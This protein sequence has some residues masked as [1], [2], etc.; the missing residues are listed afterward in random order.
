MHYGSLRVTTNDALVVTVWN[1]I[2]GQTVTIRG[3]YITPLG[4]VVPFEQT[5]SPSADRLPNTA[6]VR[7]AEGFL[8]GVKVSASAAIQRGQTFVRIALGQGLQTPPPE[9]LV[10]AQD[11]VTQAV[12]LGWPGGRISSPTEGPG[13]IRSIVG[14]TPAPGN[15]WIETVP[16]NARWRVR[17]MSF[18]FTA[19]ATAVT[20]NIGV[21][22]DD[23]AYILRVF[24]GD[25]RGGNQAYIF[26]YDDDPTQ[27]YRTGFG[28]SPHRGAIEVVGRAGYRIKSNTDNMQAGDR[29]SDIRLQVEEWID[30]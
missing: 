10:L 26:Y 8:Q 18:M 25:T 13:A 7:L 6:T 5:L 24:N 17:A 3:R 16:T 15:D 27:Y 22:L 14:T 30:V 11:Y 2:V 29:Y 23:G 1:S 20:R 9:Y 28:N 12:P 19:D 4:E 21:V